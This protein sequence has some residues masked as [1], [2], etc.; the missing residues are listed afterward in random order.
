M[1]K[2]F[3]NNSIFVKP[4]KMGIL[5]VKPLQLSFYQLLVVGIQSDLPLPFCLKGKSKIHKFSYGEEF[6]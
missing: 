2:D 5:K 3:Y 4:Q 1:K 6:W